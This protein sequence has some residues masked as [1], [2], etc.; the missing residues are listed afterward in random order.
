MPVYICQAGSSS[1]EPWRHGLQVYA[2]PFALND[3]PSGVDG[4]GKEGNYVT[5]TVTAPQLV[6]S[7]RT[8]AEMQLDDNNDNNN[9]NQNNDRQQREYHQQEDIRDGVAD[10]TTSGLIDENAPHINGTSSR[11]QRDDIIASHTVRYGLPLRK[12]RHAEVVL[13]DDVCIA[14]DRHWLRLRWPGSKGGFAGY[15]ALG[16]A[17]KDEPLVNINRQVSDVSCQESNLRASGDEVERIS[18]ACREDLITNLRR[19][20]SEDDGDEKEEVDRAEDDNV[21][22]EDDDGNNREDDDPNDEDNAST[23]SAEPFESTSVFCLRTGLAFPSSGYM[24]LMAIYDDGLS[25]PIS[26]YPVPSEP[27]FCRICREGLHDDADDEQPSP[28]MEENDAGSGQEYPS[29]SSLLNDVEDRRDPIESTNTTDLISKGPVQPH[30]KYNPNSHAAENPLISPCECSGSMAFVHYLCVEQWRCRSRHPKA[31][32]GLNCETCGN[33]YALPP[34]SARGPIDTEDWLEAMP[35]HVIDALREPHIWWRIGAGIVRRRWLRPIAPVIMSPIVALYCRARRLLK[36]KG[37]A[38]RRWAC[39]LCRRRARW[40]CVR[41][42]RSYYCSRQCQNVSWHIVHK[43]VCY[44]TSRWVWSVVVYGIA[45]LLAFPGILRDPIMYDLGIGFIPLS[46]YVMAILGGGIATALKKSIGVDL[47]GR[48]FEVIVIFLTVSLVVV[49]WG[50]LG[51][52]FGDSSKCHGVFGSLQLSEGHHLYHTLRKLQTFIL[53]PAKNWF[54]MW[55]RAAS[56]SGS[57]PRKILCMPQ[58]EVGCFEHLYKANSD[59][60][61]DVENKGRCSMDMIIVFAL[62]QFTALVAAA[63]H[64]WKRRERQRRAA[65]RPRPHQ[66]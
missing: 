7:S 16:K 32:R 60:L 37:V 6:P 64:Y 52:F 63:N 59:F 2:A 33:L 31:R 56:N 48:T 36:K 40:K 24:K 12:I 54:L 51:A 28:T 39:S 27:I 10:T 65:R 45:T 17:N 3:V 38:R 5:T 21:G 41:C 62:L 25:P 11:N 18:L 20:R 30:P 43:H 53:E 58:Q 35:P 66:D 50:L 29:S 4:E 14:F 15:V 26:S 23:L 55:D 44:K 8:E 1:S 19:G 61:F 57:W 46:F 13:V 42:L 34:P 47:R 49:S 22:N 9:I